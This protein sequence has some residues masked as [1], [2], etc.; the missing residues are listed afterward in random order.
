[1]HHD[2]ENRAAANHLALSPRGLSGANRLPVGGAPQARPSVEPQ[3]GQSNQSY[4]QELLAKLF[5]AE[6]SGAS[7]MEIAAMRNRIDYAST[8]L[9]IRPGGTPT[10]NHR[11]AFDKAG[12][13]IRV[14]NAVQPKPSLG[15]TSRVPTPQQVEQW[16]KDVETAFGYDN[17][18]EEERKLVQDPVLTRFDNYAR[19]FNFE[20]RD[21]DSVNNFLLQ[22]SKKES[23][24]THSFFKIAEGDD[25]DEFKIAFVWSKI[26]EAYRREIMRN[27]ALETIAVW[28]E[29]ERVLRNAET[30]VKPEPGPSKSRS[31]TGEGMQGNKRLASS[32]QPAGKSSGKKQDQRPSSY[33]YNDRRSPRREDRD[34]GRDTGRDAGPQ[35]SRPHSGG[36]NN[37]EKRE[38][39]RGINQ[40]GN[41][42]AHWKNR[43]EDR[44][45]DKL[46]N[47]SRLRLGPDTK[48]KQLRIAV[49]V[50]LSLPD[51]TAT[52]LRAL[53]DSGAEINLVRHDVVQRLTLDH[54][55]FHIKPVASF[56]DNNQLRIYKPYDLSLTSSDSQG[57]EKSVGPQRFWA[58]DFSGY[59]LV[60][61]YPWLREADPKIL[62]STGEVKW[63]D[64]EEKRLSVVSVEHL[65]KDIQH[66]ERAYVLHPGNLVCS[67]LSDNVKNTVQT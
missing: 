40:G 35:Q 13:L 21:R 67:T 7:A 38:D 48:G 39:S 19:F 22:L 31:S 17:L 55:L 45:N 57:V 11:P 16:I 37:R 56:L 28:A 58:A 24:L 61:G 27:G 9:G 63:W 3:P 5:E 20:W 8:I 33:G 30:A 59:D 29:F 60:L 66:S 15:S 12:K 36:W 14:L 2:N 34:A 42:R 6:V 32:T 64:Q 62:F 47:L 65:L 41:Q 50:R 1:M 25:D 44:P 54:A 18:K 52:T 49:T 46:A 10:D 4:V 26:P 53:Y 43:F 23:L 51:G